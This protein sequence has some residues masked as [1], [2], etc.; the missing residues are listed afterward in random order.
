MQGHQLELSDEPRRVTVSIDGVVIAESDHA[1]GLHETGLPI[2]YYLPRDDIRLELEATPTETVCPFKG[3]A[4]YWSVRVGGL[5]H[6]DLGWSY[7][8]P[9]EG[10]EAIAGL[11]CFYSERTDLTLDG[12]AESRPVTPWSTSEV[13]T[14][15]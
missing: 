10:M 11:V 5:E 6:R 14:T 9:I 8:H 13:R 1:V 12:Q 2:R 7:E 3:Q 15:G 4:S